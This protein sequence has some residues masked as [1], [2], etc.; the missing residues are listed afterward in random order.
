MKKVFDK[1]ISD[2][3]IEMPRCGRPFDFLQRELASGDERS[4]CAP[5]SFKDASCVYFVW[6]RTSG[7]GH[8]HLTKR[9]YA[10][11]VPS[12]GVFYGVSMVKSSSALTESTNL[13]THLLQMSRAPRRRTATRTRLPRRRARSP[14]V[15]QFMIYHSLVV[16]RFVHTS[17]RD[18]TFAELGCLPNATKGT[19]WIKK[20]DFTLKLKCFHKLCFIF[21]T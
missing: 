4:S 6:S 21:N 2:V 7:I 17:L 18:K 20:V 14:R 9:M 16:L 12:H 8:W 13:R 15:P 19:S 11:P 1:R 3:R 5:T 10:N